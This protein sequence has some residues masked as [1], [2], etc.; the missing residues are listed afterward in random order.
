MKRFPAAAMAAVFLMAG[1]AAP[2]TQ[3]AAAPPPHVAPPAMPLP[4]P[5]PVVAAP[6]AEP[7]GTGLP[8]PDVAPTVL[9][10]DNIRVGAR[11][12]GRAYWYGG[13]FT[14]RRTSS[15][16][17]LDHQAFTAAHAF[18]PFGTVVRITNLAN[19]KYA[20]VTINDRL[21]SRSPAIIDLTPRA[22]VRIGT[23][24]SGD[25]RTELVVLSLP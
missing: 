22:A 10:R 11:Q 16:Q 4:E 23:E 19:D 17:V 12:Q 7:G 21:S 20:D 8:A 2:A 9:T 5:D 14:G 15:G 24:M 6:P 13:R 3:H 25:N 1:C 18:L